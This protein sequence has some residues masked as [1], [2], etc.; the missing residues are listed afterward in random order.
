M[1]SS[2]VQGDPL[3]QGLRI[4]FDSGGRGAAGLWYTFCI[5]KTQFSE[6][7]GRPLTPAPYCVAPVLAKVHSMHLGPKISSEEL[8]FL[9]AWGHGYGLN[10]TLWGYWRNEMQILTPGSFDLPKIIFQAC[11]KKSEGACTLGAK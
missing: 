2:V 8:A 7:S 9:S 11:Q 1:S 10:Y 5:Q 4:H 6:K 3:I